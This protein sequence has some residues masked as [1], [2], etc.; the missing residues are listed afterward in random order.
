[1]RIPAF[2]SSLRGIALADVWHNDDE[3]PLGKSISIADRIIVPS[4]IHNRCAY[5]IMLDRQ[6]RFK[7]TALAKPSTGLS[8]QHATPPSQQKQLSSAL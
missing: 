4:C 2:Y 7:T 5:C 3:C 1:M 8:R 6:L